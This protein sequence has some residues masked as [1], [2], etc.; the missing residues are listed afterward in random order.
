MG[1]PMVDAVLEILRVIQGDVASSKTG[2]AT[3]KT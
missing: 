2:V 1:A 3:L